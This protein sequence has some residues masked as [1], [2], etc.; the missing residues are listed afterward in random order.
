[1]EFEADLHFTFGQPP[2]DK[3]VYWRV[4]ARRYSYVVDPEAEIYGVTRPRLEA[5]WWSVQKHTPKG[6]RLNVGTLVLHNSVKKWACPTLGEAIQSFKA[7]KNKQ[8]AILTARLNAAKQELALL[9]PKNA[10]F[11]L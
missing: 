4:E 8:I 7:R 1:M 10:R 2:A 6:V 3:E 5:T 9:E 11:A